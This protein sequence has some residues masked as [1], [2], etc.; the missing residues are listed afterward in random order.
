MCFHKKLCILVINATVGR[1]G[2]IRKAYSV[3]R[4]RARPVP[5]LAMLTTNIRCNARCPYCFEDAYNRREPDMPIEHVRDIIDELAELGCMEITLQGGESLLRDDID[6]IVGYIKSKNML[7]R[8]IS[9]GM[10]L[11]PRIAKVTALDSIG[12]SLDGDESFNDSVKNTSGYFRKAVAGLRVAR[13]K[14][15]SCSIICQMISGTRQQL[16]FLFRLAKELDIGIQFLYTFYSDEHGKDSVF[17]GSLSGDDYRGLIKDILEAKRQ[18]A[19]VLASVKGLR[20]SANWDRH[21]QRPHTRNRIVAS[22]IPDGVM[23]PHCYAGKNLIHIEN[24]G[25]IWPCSLNPV[26]GA[27]IF[28]S[29]SVAKAIAKL[30]TLKD[31]CVDCVNPPHIDTNAIFSFDIQTVINYLKV[32]RKYR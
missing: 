5:L 4:N 29:G 31:D 3:L 23:R 10:L 22:E 19:P 20:H 14:G 7:A 28:E 16:P 12:I 32:Y 11:A 24:N 6:E 26:K 1:M 25:D 18:G 30:Q 8:L 27:N 9:N 15:I 2:I 21:Y 17:S 13:A